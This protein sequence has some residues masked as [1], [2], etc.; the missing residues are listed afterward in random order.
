MAAQR[1]ALLLE[2]EKLDQRANTFF[3]KLRTKVIDQ[4]SSASPLA[5]S[6]DYVLSGSGQK[7]HLKKDLQNL[8]KLFY[9]DDQS[10]L[11]LL[12]NTDIVRDVCKERTQGFIDSSTALTTEL[13]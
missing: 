9:I 10:N 3:E 12:V 4:L 6:F 8:I 2:F 13:K 11:Q 1:A 5:S 7:Q